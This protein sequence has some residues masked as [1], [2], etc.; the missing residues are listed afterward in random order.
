ME[1]SHEALIRKLESDV[2]EYD[3]VEDGQVRQ[4]DKMRIYDFMLSAL[5]LS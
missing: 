4:T 3:N 1:L 5:G 2:K